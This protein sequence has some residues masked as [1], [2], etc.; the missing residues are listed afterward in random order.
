MQIVSPGPE[1]SGNV[2]AYFLKKKQK[3][4]NI[5]FRKIKIHCYLQGNFIYIFAE[6]DQ[7]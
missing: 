3:N 1:R 7:G 4:I 5:F 6:G 2:K